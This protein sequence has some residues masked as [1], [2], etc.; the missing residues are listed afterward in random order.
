MSPAM[1]APE[2]LTTTT[3]DAMKRAGGQNRQQ[4]DFAPPTTS[5][6]TRAED[7]GNLSSDGFSD[8]DQITPDNAPGGGDD[9]GGDNMNA[10]DDAGG[11][12][13]MGDDMGGDDMGMGEDGGGGDDFG[14][15]GMSDE[16]EPT[17]T[18]EEAI[19]I[20]NLQ[21][22]ISQ[23][24]NILVNTCDT[25]STTTVPSS[26]EELRRLYSSSIAHLSEAKSMAFDLLSTKFTP[27]NYAY[28][29]RKYLALR[30]LYSTVLEVIKLHSDM[31]NGPE[32]PERN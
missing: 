1:E 6:E 30:H 23:F 26:T 12:M 17:A 10:G 18:P 11:D 22:G 2:D 13:G 3:N 27:G 7:G 32:S 21:N 8:I 9:A 25:L 29:L 20:Q 5:D 19:R 24:Y 4:S 28:K 31:V 15:S 16:A 14:G